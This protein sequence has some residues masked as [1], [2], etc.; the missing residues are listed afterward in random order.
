MPREQSERQQVAAIEF[1]L[2][3][4]VDVLD[5]ARRG[6]DRRLRARR[7]WRTEFAQVLHHP[8]ASIWGLH[9]PIA[10]VPGVRA[11]ALLQTARRAP[12]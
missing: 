3:R 8:R 9:E 6:S 7:C 12:Q 5:R 4:T 2:E 10:F 11:D 1:A